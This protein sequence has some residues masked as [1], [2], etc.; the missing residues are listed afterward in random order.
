MANQMTRPLDRAKPWIVGVSAA[1][2]CYIGL[3]LIEE[4][5]IATLCREILRCAL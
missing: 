4:W 1:I 5:V 2:I 3:T